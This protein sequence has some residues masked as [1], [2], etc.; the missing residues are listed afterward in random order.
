MT[1]TPV[2]GQL[3][4]HAYLTKKLRTHFFS[5]PFSISYE[6]VR[7]TVEEMLIVTVLLRVKLCGKVPKIGAFDTHF[8]H[9]WY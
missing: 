5:T 4:R 6:N 7:R 3:G 9:S 2:V 8:A 1:H